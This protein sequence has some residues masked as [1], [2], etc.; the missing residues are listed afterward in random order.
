[1]ALVK[2]TLKVQEPPADSVKLVGC[3]EL[4][5]PGVAVGV[6]PT[7]VELALGAGALTRPGT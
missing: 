5:A 4:P 3:A 6:A 2:V 1:M 7:Q